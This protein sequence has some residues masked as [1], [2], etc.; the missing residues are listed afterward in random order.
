MRTPKFEHEQVVALPKFGLTG[1]APRPPSATKQACAAS[2]PEQGVR[3]SDHLIQTAIPLEPRFQQQSA[4]RLPLAIALLIATFVH[5]FLLI[6]VRID[7]FTSGTGSARPILQITLPDEERA[8]AKGAATIDDEKDNPSEPSSAPAPTIASP[9]EQPES[10]RP[11]AGSVSQPHS[12]RD[13]QELTEKAAQDVVAQENAQE[14]RRADMWRRTRSVMFAPPPD[15]LI[16]DEPY[17]PDL[18]FD[19]RR[20]KG[21]G[22]KIGESCYFGIPASMPEEADSDA[23]ESSTVGNQS[24]GSRLINCNF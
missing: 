19:D 16:A 2:T 1:P 13:W 22:F 20:F 5:A 4:A 24:T 8:N 15:S 23:T 17:L 7:L 6:F 9:S 21:I 12:A 18:P 3:D 11:K 10:K 14:I